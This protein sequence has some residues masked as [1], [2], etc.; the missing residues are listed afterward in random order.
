MAIAGTS[1]MIGGGDTNL[2]D[3][4]RGLGEG[5]E[6]REQSLALVDLAVRQYATSS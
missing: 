6:S 1:A 2:A 3:R 5:D 4:S